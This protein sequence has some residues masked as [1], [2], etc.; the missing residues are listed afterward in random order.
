MARD[1]ID[2]QDG[3]NRAVRGFLLLYG[4]SRGVTLG[5]MKR[6]LSNYGFPDWPAWVDDYST[7]THLTKGGAQSWLRHLFNLEKTNG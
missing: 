5:E 6:H 7:N 1:L 2:E 4:G 3:E